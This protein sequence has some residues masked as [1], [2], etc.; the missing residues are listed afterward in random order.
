MI[1]WQARNPDPAV[2][3]QSKEAPSQAGCVS[4][5]GAGQPGQRIEYGLA[6]SNSSCI[7]FDVDFAGRMNHSMRF[8]TTMDLLREAVALQR[9][10][11]VAE[12]AA[13]YSE[14]LRAEPDNADAYYYLGMM[15]CQAGRFD[16][17]AEFARKAL[18]RN[19]R[20]ANAHMLLGRAL[21]ALGWPEEALKSLQQATLLDSDLATAHGHLGD[22]LSDLGRN[23]EAIESY[24]R[25]LA[26]MP[27]RVDDWFNRGMA[28]KAIDRN[29]EALESFERV[30]AAK[31]EL[32][33]AHSE[34]ANMLWRLHRYDEALQSVDWALASDPDLTE[35]WH[36]RGTILYALGQYD[37]ALA[38]YDKALTLKPDFVE[39]WLGRGNAFRQCKRYEESLAAHGEALARKPEFAEAWFGRGNVFF[40][41]KRFNEAFA[42]YDKALAFKPDFAQAHF[43]AGCLN[44]LLGKMELGWEKYEYRWE[45]EQSHSLKRNFLQPLWLGEDIRD[46][47]IL[48]HAEQGFGDTLLACRYI[49]MVAACGA[50]VVLE[51]QP[52]L[53]SLLHGFEGVVTL[54]GRGEPLPDFDVHCPLM[55]LPLAFK[56]TIQTIPTIVPYLTVP[57][58]AIE[59]WHL[60][61]G[62][63]RLKVGIAW[64]GNPTFENDRDR[65]ILLKNILPVSRIAGAKYFCLQKDLRHGDAEILDANPQIMRLHI[66]DFQDTAAVMMSLD[67][68]ISS[69][70]SIVN[71]AGALGRPV[72]V[73]LP[74]IPDW[75][76]LL[77]RDITPWYSTAKLFRQTS[78]GD[79]TTVLDDICATLKHLVAH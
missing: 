26:L 59:K 19:A 12:A 53:K 41:L 21:S 28:L 74:F 31:P 67:L 44:L 35:A 78:I 52:A 9:R 54:I 24:D 15:S 8:S 69:D 46:K 75:R 34:R 50:K 38:A 72:W 55:S 25:A 37:G 18:A 14:V 30:I 4:K 48:L 60:K 76:W 22:I 32:A 51:I 68:V 63:E 2:Q 36:S 79:W 33:R 5:N 23:S 11:A 70:T 40:E 77:E 45:T 47:V 17:G 61:L 3:P 66:D 62:T 56:T 16:E 58:A 29:E 42:A 10:G 27:E 39:A 1:H 64:A 57:R 20:H 65:S 43:S 6:G 71:L 13:R 7:G 49:P 73:L